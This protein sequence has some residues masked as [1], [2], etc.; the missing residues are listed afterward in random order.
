MEAGLRHADVVMM[1]RIQ[2]ERMGEGEFAVSLLEYHDNYG[3]THDRL[4]VA[5]PDVIVLHP[6]PVNRGVEIT[7]ELADDLKYSRIREQV[8]MGVASRM[9]ILDLLLSP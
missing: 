9:A 8:E 5:K 6:G 7:N 1:L 3:L 4:K 2:H